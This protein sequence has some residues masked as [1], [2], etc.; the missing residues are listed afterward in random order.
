LIAKF[1]SSRRPRA[2]EF[3][4][5]VL[6]GGI[7][8]FVDFGVLYLSKSFLFSS[9]NGQTTI[10]LAAALGFTAGL[11]FNYILSLIFVFRR[12]NEKA[13]Q[14]KIR[15]FVLFAVIGIIGLLVTEFC[16]FVGIH[17]FG[18]EWYSAVKVIT[19]GIV[20]IWNYAARRILIF[21]EAKFESQQYS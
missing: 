14:Y 3:F 11:V 21:R 9:M 2:H 6:V 12:K 5:Y 8:F 16:M 18:Q 20:L 1:L 7:S 15:T 19:A 4:R 13:K 10:L 17:I